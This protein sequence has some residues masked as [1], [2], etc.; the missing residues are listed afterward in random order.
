MMLPRINIS[1]ETLLIVLE[2]I[3]V[4]EAAM[5]ERVRVESEDFQMKNLDGVGCSV[6]CCCW[7]CWSV[8]AVI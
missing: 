2:T 7:L 1:K 8:A 6:F 4:D 5:N 3:M